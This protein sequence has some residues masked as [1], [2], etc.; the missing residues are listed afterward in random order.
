M[1]TTLAVDAF[2]ASRR[3]RRLSP[4]TI[5]WYA[6]ILDRF[7]RSY[8]ELPLTPEP[9]EY[10]IGSC[11]GGDERAHGYFRA[12]RAFYRHLYRRQAISFNPMLMLDAPRRE[13]KEPHF[14]TPQ[15]LEK[16]L[17][18]PHEAKIKAALMFLADTGCRVGELA[19]LKLED[20]HDNGD[21]WMATVRGKTGTRIVPNS[22]DVYH[23]MMT[24]APLGWSVDALSRRISKAFKDAGVRGTAHTLRHTFATLW[25]GDESILQRIL[26]HSTIGTTLIYRHTRMQLMLEAHAQHSPLRILGQQRLF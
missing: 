8:P 15:D 2:L 4:R 22:Y 10:F 5:K 1:L 6:D 3:A 17:E 14:L 9:I 23:A 19:N 7:V 11:P 12:L 18:Y 13:H 20:L 24:N 26:G 21:Y 16:L 25:Q